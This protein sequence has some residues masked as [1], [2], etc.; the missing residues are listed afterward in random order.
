MQTE[1]TL[2]GRAVAAQ[3]IQVSAI[4]LFFFRTKLWLKSPTPY[5]T[6][7][8]LTLFLLAWWLATEVWRL[9]RFD[10]LPGPA[11]VL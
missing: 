9:P 11:T 6:L 8:G 10:K 5:L 1:E 4:S 3:D 7:L 2:H